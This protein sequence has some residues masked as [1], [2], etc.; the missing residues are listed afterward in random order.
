MEIQKFREISASAYKNIQSLTPSDI[1]TLRDIL[2][3]NTINYGHIRTFSLKD[4]QTVILLTLKQ[5]CLILIK[6][7]LENEIKLPESIL[8]DVIDLLFAKTVTSGEGELNVGTEVDLNAQLEKERLETQ[9]FNC[10]VDIVYKS[11]HSNGKLREFL[12]AKSVPD[13]ASVNFAPI[14]TCEY[15]S[16]ELIVLSKFV[17]GPVLLSLISSYRKKLRSVVKRHIIARLTSQL[18]STDHN[19]IYQIFY[20]INEQPNIDLL[21]D[22]PTE[23]TS[24]YLG[25]VCSLIRDKSSCEIAYEKLLPFFDELERAFSVLIGSSK[26]EEKKIQPQDEEII[27]YALEC[28]AKMVKYKSVNFY[29]FLTSIQVLLKLD[30]SSHI[31][32]IIYEILGFYI[33]DKEVYIEKPADCRTAVKEELLKKEFF[34]LP[35][36]IHFINIHRK[37]E[38]I[39][40]QLRPRSTAY[41]T[42]NSFDDKKYGGFVSEN[43]EYL[44]YLVLGFQSED[45]VTVIECLDAQVPL[46]ILTLNAAHIKNA[47]VK[48][49]RVVDR[50]LAYQVTNGVI[51]E[52]IS[53]IN[54]IIS[55]PND[56]FFKYACLFKNFTF[57]FNGDVLERMA[58]NLEEGIA[59][60]SDTYSRSVG[61][62]ILANCGFFNDILKMNRS[63]QTLILP[64]YERI[65]KDYYGNIEI[66]IRGQGEQEETDTLL[67]FGDESDASDSF[68]N[69]FISQLL[70]AK[71][72]NPGSISK[73]ILPKKYCHTS[74]S[75][76]C[77]AKVV[78]GYDIEADIKF[79]K[80]NLMN[81]D[82]LVGYW[83]ITTGNKLLEIEGVSEAPEVVSTSVLRN[84][85][86]KD[87]QYFLQHFSEASDFEKFVLFFSVS[88]VN[89]EIEALIKDEVMKNLRSANKT[90]LDMCVLQLFK[91]KDIDNILKALEK[92]YDNKEVLFKLNIHNVICGGNYFSKSLITQVNSRLMC[93]AIFVIN[94][95]EIWESSYLSELV[96]KI[97]PDVPEDMR[98]YISDIKQY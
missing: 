17:I 84:L 90:Y 53:V 98:H 81:T 25:F 57:Y 5:N 67:V 35:R 97:W 33:M 32:G 48:D 59:W 27:R 6:F 94:H 28:I 66:L 91:C 31:K 88:E 26:I 2:K 29:K 47:M 37:R 13:D 18:G 46:E 58:D 20:L 86:L 38:N 74:Y 75:K 80:A 44:G 68:F 65:L 7:L 64:I 41:E 3:L 36:L 73:F 16:F 89:L 49:P 82:E 54:T 78:A 24:Q 14:I 69:I 71:F 62:F 50:L 1:E 45:P 43:D 85:G 95:L 12:S 11:R 92:H 30:T 8:N 77:K 10:V 55:T 40:R 72:Y 19:I 60:L 76:Y 63:V 93:Q 42:V 70:Y 52:D 34:L 4:S 56:D 61:R 87:S 23:N 9:I 51:L 96:C 79:M 15:K 22:R 83:E 39:E 21:S